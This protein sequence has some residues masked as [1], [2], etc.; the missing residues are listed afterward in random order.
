MGDQ[1]EAC[2]GR[3]KAYNNQKKLV[4]KPTMVKK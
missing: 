2:F 4:A 3:H 1:N